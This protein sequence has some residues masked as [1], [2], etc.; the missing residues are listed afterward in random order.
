MTA[1]LISTVFDP[2]AQTDPKSV[3]DTK[4]FATL[5]ALNPWSTQ[6]NA[7]GAYL[8]NISDFATTYEALANYKGA[9]S[10]LS[11]ALAMP[12]T[13]SHSGAIYALTADVADVTAHTPGVSGSWQLVRTNSTQ[14]SHGSG[15]VE[16]SLNSLAAQ[17][18]IINGNFAVNQ[19]ALTSPV[20]ASANAQV[21]SCWK[22]GASGVTYS[23]A[24]T[25]GVTTLTIT[26][27]TLV[28]VIDG[29]DIAA[30]DYT[31]SWT[32]TAT[33]RINGVAYGSAGSATATLPG[34]T[35]ATL[36][37]GTG[38]ISRV[39]MVPGVVA[40]PY[41]RRKLADELALCE[42]RLP[43]LS[44]SGSSNIATGMVLGAGSGVITL[45]LKST[46]RTSPTGLLMI[47]GGVGALEA[48]SGVTSAALTGVTFLSA[49]DSNVVLAVTWSG[50]PSSVGATI[51]VNTTSSFVRL[52]FT[53]AEL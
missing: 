13:A 12:A 2:P 49:N 36:E 23:F 4:A 7:L 16:D 51:F 22:A 40:Q 31:A 1:P 27:G 33:G 30:G 28:Q 38:T 25:A 41:V 3:F 48:V 15:T 53:G 10:A 43:T 5:L 47:G 29:N 9:W 11:G 19:R 44:G 14:I 32:G 26:S 45:S 37:I 20:T 50:S 35:N 8:D 6:A 24:T 21:H 34:G 17:N 52:L 18:L 39:N 42:F 46:P